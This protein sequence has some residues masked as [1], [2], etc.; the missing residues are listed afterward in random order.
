[1]A[2]FRIERF[3]VKSFLDAMKGFLDKVTFV[4]GCFAGLLIFCC[5][6]MRAIAA[7]K[8]TAVNFLEIFMNTTSFLH[9]QL[10]L[11]FDLILILFIFFIQLI[12]VI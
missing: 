2:P 6:M 5:G 1:M 4:V 8:A 3:S 11:F 10:R 7:I 12:I 9:K